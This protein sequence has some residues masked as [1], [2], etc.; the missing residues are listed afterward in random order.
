MYTYFQQLKKPLYPIRPALPPTGV[1]IN[2]QG[3]PW[4]DRDAMLCV[5]AKLTPHELAVCALVCKAWAEYS[6]SM[7]VIMFFLIIDPSIVY[8]IKM[9]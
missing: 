9:S 2:T 5:F 8:K 7:S 1:G 4:L 6:V 3:S